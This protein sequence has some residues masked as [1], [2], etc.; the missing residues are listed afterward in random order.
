MFTSREALPFPLPSDASATLCEI[1]P[2]G[3]LAE[4]RWPN[5]SDYQARVKTFYESSAYALAWIQ[6]GAPTPQALSLIEALQQADNKGLHAE[7]YDGPRW[8]DRLARMRQFPS[9]AEGRSR[10]RLRQ[11]SASILRRNHFLLIVSERS[12]E[13]D[14]RPR[15]LAPGV[16]FMF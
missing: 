3:Q 6:S 8:V 1:V 11:E 13:Q 7:D 14:A 2:T 15:V 5:F 16:L 4:L 12:Q 10:S 9:A